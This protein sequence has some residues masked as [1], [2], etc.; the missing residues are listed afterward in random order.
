MKALNRFGTAD[1]GNVAMMFGIL[2]VPLLIAAGVGLDM[3][4]TGQVRGE[5]QEAADAGLLAA[6]R[7]KLKDD[8]LSDAALTVIA[9]KHFDANKGAVGEVLIETFDFNFNTAT[10]KATLTTTGKVRTAIMGVVGKPYM[11]IDVVSGAEVVKPRALEVVLAL[12]N[13]TSMSGAK[14]VSLKDSARELVDAIMAD[15]DNK[16]KVGLVPFGRHVQ[17][18]MSRAGEAWLDVPADS[19]WDQNECNVDEP[20]AAAAGCAEQTITCHDDGVPY[21]C[22]EWQCPAGAP[23]PYN[24]AL[25]SH[26]TTWLGCVGS[27]PHPLNIEDRDYLSNRIPGVLNEAIWGGDCPNE[28]TPITTNKVDVK[29]DIANL[30]VRGETYIPSGLFWAQALISGEAPF[31]EGKTYAA[32]TEESG[33]KAIVLMTDGEN[34]ASPSGSGDHYATDADE[35]DDYTLELC[36]EIKSNGI[37]LYT[38]AFEVTDAATQAMLGDCATSSDAY[39]NAADASALLEAFGEIGSNL[40]ELALTQ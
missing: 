18:G 3:M 11:E 8:S 12:D 15:T 30:S 34:T 39:F 33:V 21:A 28:I 26:P 1:A 9:R 19:S 37:I 17:I 25:V 5:L 31:T 14:L 24:C 4:R 7:A 36:E 16:V 40:Q 6:S 29:N 38:I 10:K 22:E 2:I 13:T 27:R 32:M 23:P 35:A 20:A